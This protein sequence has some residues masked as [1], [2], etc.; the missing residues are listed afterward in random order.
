MGHEEEGREKEREK[1]EERDD[2]VYCLYA[3][4]LLCKTL[5]LATRSSFCCR[6]QE[7]ILKALSLVTIGGQRT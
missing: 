7:S 6:I 3:K 1:R 2:R 5:G 4:S